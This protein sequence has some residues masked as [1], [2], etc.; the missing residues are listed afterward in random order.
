[1]PD[2]IKRKYPHEVRLIHAVTNILLVR[3]L[4]VLI[5]L[6]S[7]SL[8]LDSVEKAADLPD[9]ETIGRSQNVT[10]FRCPGRGRP[11]YSLHIISNGTYEIGS[12]VKGV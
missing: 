6:I 8:T 9:E 2:L 10:Q 5:G 1:M 11:A 12:R 4:Y 7:N 3:Y